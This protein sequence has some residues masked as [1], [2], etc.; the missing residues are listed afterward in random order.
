MKYHERN[1]DSRFIL[2]LVV[3]SILAFLVIA[4]PA[5]NFHNLLHIF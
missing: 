2:C 3:T 5:I 4:V 1:E